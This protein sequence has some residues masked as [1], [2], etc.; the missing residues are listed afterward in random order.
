[1]DTNDNSQLDFF[2][3]SEESIN[4]KNTKKQ[5]MSYIRGYEKTIILI[6]AFMV[7]A[8]IAFGLGVRHGGQLASGPDIEQGLDIHKTE[9]TP[10]Q[11]K[12]VKNL[13]FEAPVS[14]K[15][16][17]PVKEEN[18]E[19]KQQS[20]IQ[21]GIYT[22]QVAS[23]TNN[24]AAKKEAERLRKNGHNP[25]IQSKGKYTVVFIGSFKTKENAKTELSK[26]QKQYT[27][28]FIRRL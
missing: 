3:Q 12:Q 25:L 13:T 4:H 19:T 7:V 10:G 26:L 20:A 17:T 23:F 1:M 5:F 8:I 22:I 18:I 27:D 16:N 14:V 9:V 2:S 6:I 15:I 28:C 11:E 21:Q 24:I